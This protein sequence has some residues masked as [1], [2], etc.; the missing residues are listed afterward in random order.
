[1]RRTLSRLAVAGGVAFALLQFIRPAI[2]SGPATAE[3]QAPPA[4]K[5][6]LKKDCYSCHSND[7]RLAWFDEIEPAYLLVRKDILEARGRLNFSTIGAKPAAAQ[8]GAL[9]E[10]VAMM[11]SGTM[12]PARFTM[13]HPEAKVTP[14][15]LRTIKDVLAPWTEPVPPL[16]SRATPRAG[17]RAAVKP[18]PTGLAY[19]ESWTHWKLLAITDRGDNR[20]FRMIVGNDVAVT[21]VRTGNVSPWPDG[22]RLAKLAWLQGQ[23]ADGL[24]VPGKFWQIEL[25]V[26]DAQRYKDSDGWGWGRWRSSELTPYGEDA[27]VVQECTG[28]HLPVK[29]H[30][31][32]YTQPFSTALAAGAALNTQA[33]TLPARLGI[34]PLEWTPVTLFIDPR[35]GTISVLFAQEQDGIGAPTGSAERALVTWTQREDPYWFGA[36]VAGAVVSVETTGKAAAERARFL[37]ALAPV[38][39]P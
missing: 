38:A 20:Q 3:I 1:M 34:Q 28:C 35:A 4:L 25:M 13:L 2:P 29:N 6:V 18:S 5:A 14:E 39:V 17:G 9:Y 31:Y 23:T 19:D 24:I 32:V 11:Q 12:P 15:D 21:A 26:K 36:R 8:K 16:D 27:G 37:E 30:D 22:A 7:R 33:A 10:A